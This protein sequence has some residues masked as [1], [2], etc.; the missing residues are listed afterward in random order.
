MQYKKSILVICPF[1]QG[2]AAGQRLKYE[3]YLNHWQE[4]G[5]E[6]TISSFMDMPM[7]KIVYTPQNYMSKIFGTLRGHCRRLCDIFRVSRYDLVYIFMWV[8][9]FGS[10]TFERL[11]RLLS[12]HIVYDIEDNFLE[13]QKGLNPLITML[14][15]TGKARYLIK[16]S[17]HVIT[18]SPFLNDY[19]LGVNLKKAST[20]ISSSVNTKYFTPKNTYNNKKKVTIGWTGTFSSKRHLDLLENVF[21]QLNKRIDFKL[22]VICNFHYNQWTKKTE[23]KDLQ[24]IDIGIYP[25]VQDDWVLGKSGLKAIQ[26]MAFGL[27]T[28]A[29]DV[30][31]TPTII[32][33]MVNG[34]LVT[35]DEEWIVALEELI[36]NPKLRQ[37]LGKAARLTV[38]ENYSNDVIKSNYLTILNNVTGRRT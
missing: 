24:G 1:P 31:T 30:G 38:L 25:L 14:K 11:Y 21:L 22:R 2:V 4:N 35:T 27:P 28:V 29:T 10:S 19:C 3:Q 26:Y 37:D 16:T 32:K 23:V 20:F 12:N 18:S 17:D 7:W 9:P 15:G 13:E 5:Y 34:W 6:I 36:K 33:H 8:T